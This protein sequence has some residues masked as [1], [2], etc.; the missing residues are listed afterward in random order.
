MRS[1][2]T[3]S[4]FADCHESLD[5]RQD[6]GQSSPFIDRIILGDSRRVLP[7]LPSE[8]VDLIHTSPPYN[9]EKLYAHSADD[10]DHDEYLQFLV[11][12]FSACYR[13]LKPGASLFLQAGYSQNQTDEIVP[14]DILSHGPLHRMGYRLWDRIIWHYR[15]GMAFKRKF[16]NTHE[17]ILWWVKPR[18][19]GSFQPSFDVDAVRERS[20]SYDR[21]N[22]L[23][24]KNPG[25]V[26]S[27]DRVAFGGHARKH[28][29]HCG[30]PRGHHGADHPRVL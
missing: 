16:K 14:I 17:T 1:G 2:R 26:W 13:L 30:L 7:K 3:L 4:A 9:I 5:W 23:S 24:G 20:K 15:G 22:N 8:S 29:S 11:D 21:R 6:V 10:L 12:V 18:S 25:N 19:D 28:V 27:E